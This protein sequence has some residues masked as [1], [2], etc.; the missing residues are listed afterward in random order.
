MPKDRAFLDVNAR[1]GAPASTYRKTIAKGK[2][3]IQLEK[4]STHI[5]LTLPRYY[6]PPNQ[7]RIKI[8]KL[9]A[10]KL[11]HWLLDKASK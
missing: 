1:R 5:I 8:T 3:S 4:T 2:N 7:S 10:I 6:S 9:N 11:A